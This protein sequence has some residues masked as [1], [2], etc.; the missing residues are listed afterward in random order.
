LFCKKIGVKNNNYGLGKNGVKKQNFG[1]K[2][3]NRY[4]GVIDKKFWGKELV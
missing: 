3:A 4:C 1:V 2:K